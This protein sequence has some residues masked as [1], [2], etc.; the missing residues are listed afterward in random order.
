MSQASC[1]RNGANRI[2]NH[3]IVS[4]SAVATLDQLY[5][6]LYGFC[7]EEKVHL[8][9]FVLHTGGVSLTQT[10]LSFGDF[11]TCVGSFATMAEA[12]MIE[13]MWSAT[14]SP[15]QSSTSSKREKEPEATM[16]ASFRPPVNAGRLHELIKLQD[17]VRRATLGKSRWAKK[18]DERTRVQELVQHM[19]DHAGE[20]PAR[21]WKDWV[22][23]RF[24]DDSN[25]RWRAQ[26]L[27]AQ[28]RKGSSTAR[29][30]SMS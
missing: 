28:H 8:I 17:A 16:A 23:S 9:Q 3:G 1:N 24:F 26:H 19:R 6:V 4:C 11:V 2:A 10:S 12:D 30:L 29:D 13:C 21:G 7:P 18:T 27:Y 25:L 15:P 5:G 14:A 22:Q 20:L